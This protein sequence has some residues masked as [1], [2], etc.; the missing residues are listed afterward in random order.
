ME[1]PLSNSVGKNAKILPVHAVAGLRGKAIVTSRLLTLCRFSSMK[2]AGFSHALAMDEVE[3]FVV[4]ATKAD[5]WRFPITRNRSSRPEIQA[6]QFFSGTERFRARFSKAG[7]Q[8]P[9]LAWL[10]WQQDCSESRFDCWRHGFDPV[11][12]DVTE[13]SFSVGV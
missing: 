4:V 9:S 8:S 2:S 3:R 7:A 13:A 11:R 5:Q 6:L 10:K 1:D 12:Q